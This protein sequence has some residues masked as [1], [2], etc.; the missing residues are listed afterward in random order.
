MFT[1]SQNTKFLLKIIKKKFFRITVFSIIAGSILFD[2]LMLTTL[3]TNFTFS[4]K[5]QILFASLV[6]VSFALVFYQ[7]DAQI[8]WNRRQLSS[9]EL[10][11][12]IAENA[13]AR[14]E[15]NKFFDYS[16]RFKDELENPFGIDEIHMLI[17]EFK[18][19]RGRIIYSCSSAHKDRPYKLTKDGAL[20][21]HYMITILNNFEQIASNIFHGAFDEDMCRNLLDKGVSQNY[22]VYGHYIQHLRGEHH[23]KD[24]HA[25]ENF[26]W[27]AERWGKKP[28]SPVSRDSAT[29][30]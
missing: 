23:Y 11:R 14:S 26:Q 16:G 19:E 27:L 30:S 21:K 7:M 9:T 6:S 12:Y 28:L 24:E 18:E 4:E 5:A 10:S 22:R 20:I 3:S 8:D 25:L 13:V 17:C 29:G 1:S 15:L 2:I